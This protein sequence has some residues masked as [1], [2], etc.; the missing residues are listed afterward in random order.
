E[1]AVH[2]ENELRAVAQRTPKAR[3]VGRPES[4]LRRPVQHVDVAEL[5]SEPVG[6]V[7]GTVRR[8]VVDHEDP[9]AVAQHRTQRAH[10]RLEVLELVVRREA[11][12]RAHVLVTQCGESIGTYDRR[13]AK[14]Q[15]QRAALPRNDMLAAQFQ[16]LADLMELEGADGFRIAAYRRAATR[17]L[18][19]GS[20]VARLALDGRAKELQ[21][22]GRTIEEK[23]VEGVNDGEIHEL[24]ERKAGVAIEVASFKRLPGLGPKTARR[25]WKELGITTVDELREAAEAHRLRDLGGLGV[26]SEEK[27][28]AALSKPKAAEGPRR[29]LLGN[30]LPRLRA[31]EAEVAAHPA[32]LQVSIAGSARRFREAVREPHLIPTAAD[33]PAPNRAVCGGPRGGEGPGRG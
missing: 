21:G 20:S 15:P 14:A 26:K 27:I 31:V 9:V 32:A 33:P 3:D 11:D 2:L 7:A 28:L 25:I 24:T 5:Q 10:H 13:V 1:V 17:I 16:L 30:V 19:T 22:I 4:L 8:G 6:E 12:G 23:I 18:E 29:A